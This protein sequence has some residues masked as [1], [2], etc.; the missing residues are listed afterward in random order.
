VCFR[1]PVICGKRGT[2]SPPNDF[3][4]SSLLWRGSSPS[5]CPMF[6]CPTP[7]GFATADGTVGAFCQPGGHFSRP[8]FPRVFLFFSRI[9]HSLSKR[10]LDVTSCA[11]ASPTITILS[12]EFLLSAGWSDQGVSIFRLFVCREDLRINNGLCV[13]RTFRKFVNLPQAAL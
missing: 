10:S 7:P 2:F 11:K 9:S 5:L 6:S 8:H 4:S 3:P 12:E 13:I 1:F